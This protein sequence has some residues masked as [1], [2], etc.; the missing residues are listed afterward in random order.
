[1]DRR[2]IGSM[3][4]EIES[5]DLPFAT[6]IHIELHE[7]FTDSQAT[8]PGVDSNIE[9]LRFLAHISKADKTQDRVS[10][11]TFRFMNK[12]MGQRVP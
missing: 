8:M 1:M 11:D 10:F 12:T 5:F 2:W 6:K 9:K 3:N 4:F 7:S